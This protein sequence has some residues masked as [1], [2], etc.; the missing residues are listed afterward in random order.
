MKTSIEVKNL[1]KRY[2]EVVALDNQSITVEAGEFLAL[3]GPSGCGKTTL[4]RC[5][6]GL[7]EPEE[8]EISIQGET[9]FSQNEGILTPAGKRNVGMVFQSYALWPHMTVLDNVGFGLAQQKMPADEIKK[10]V[11][12][13]LRDLQMESMETRFPFELS[14]GQQQRVALARLLASKPPVFLMDEP[15]SN[16]DVRLRLDMRSEIKRLHYES[17]ATTIYVTHDQIEALT[18]ASKIAVMKDGRI[19]QLAAPMEVYKKPANIF[20]AKFVGM[21]S[22][23]LLPAKTVHLNGQLWLDMETIKVLA[24]WPIDQEETIVA[25]RPENFEVFLEPEEDAAQFSVYAVLPSGPEVIIHARSQDTNL[26]I[27]ETRPLDI[28]M[29]QPLWIKIDS[30]AVNLYDPQTEELLISAN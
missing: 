4:L 22:I 19:Q 18:M 30:S 24:P 5:I 2:G 25:V 10:V 1:T 26:V 28:Q 20:V 8:G 9:V 7:E 11:K 17:D 13:V 27:R 16:L 23:N 15:L 12:S 14:G 21:P 6:S 29:D 3:V